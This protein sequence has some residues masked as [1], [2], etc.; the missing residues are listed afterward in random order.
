MNL[1]LALLLAVV[2]TST[3]GMTGF[4]TLLVL[5]NLVIGMLAA[6]TR[7]ESSSSLGNIDHVVNLA[8]AKKLE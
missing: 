4:L 1:S 8:E 5:G 2:S 7:T 6:F 3:L